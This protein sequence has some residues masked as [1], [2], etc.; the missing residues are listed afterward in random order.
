METKGRQVVTRTDPHPAREQSEAGLWLLKLPFRTLS[1]STVHR[2]KKF[3]NQLI[4]LLVRSAN[5]PSSTPTR[6]YSA[7]KGIYNTTHVADHATPTRQRLPPVASKRNTPPIRPWPS[8][9]GNPMPGVKVF[10]AGQIHYHLSRPLV[11]ILINHRQTLQTAL[12][13]TSSQVQPRCLRLKRLQ[14]RQPSAWDVL[15]L[16][17]SKKRKN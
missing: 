12:L 3:Q 13:R 1:I 8:R 17:D 10:H 9:G 15:C 14:S 2:A 6:H 5:S 16:V 4:F 7:P 11:D